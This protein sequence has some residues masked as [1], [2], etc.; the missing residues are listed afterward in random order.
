M[1]QSSSPVVEYRVRTVKEWSRDQL[2]LPN[3]APLA[4]AQQEA[5]RLLREEDFVLNES[6]HEALNVLEAEGLGTA[7]LGSPPTF[8]NE[9]RR[10]LVHM[11]NGVAK[12][13]FSFPPALR[14]DIL[15]DLRNLAQPFPELRS[16][17]DAL[18]GHAQ[19]T[20]PDTK[21]DSE[22]MQRLVKLLQEYAVA[23]PHEQAWLRRSFVA[24]DTVSEWSLR[25]AIE[26]L[27]KEHAPWYKAFARCL[28]NLLYQ[29]SNQA[30]LNTQLFAMSE[31]SN[32]ATTSQVVGESRPLIVATERKRTSTSATNGWSGWWVVLAIIFGIVRIASIGVNSSSSSSTLPPSYKMPPIEID[33]R[34]LP[35]DG[36]LRRILG[37]EEFDENQQQ[38]IKAGQDYLIKRRDQAN[39]GMAPA[40]PGVRPPNPNQPFVPNYNKS[41]G[42]SPNVP[43]IPKPGVPRSPQPPQ[44]GPGRPVLPNMGS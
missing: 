13:Y 44:P 27:K 33:V 22:T 32:V 36:P 3:D 4:T 20:T 16:R 40:V 1:N 11:V 9:Q 34:T 30:Q 5:W 15:A 19:L 18:H 8:L 42:R 12:A 29:K 7:E 35:K 43:S 28:D 23:P 17:V 25:K 31:N 38:N 10:N 26:R 41:Q 37:V 2:N 24:D 39:P 21:S 14:T 6:Q